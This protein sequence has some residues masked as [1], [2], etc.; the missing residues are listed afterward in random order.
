MGGYKIRSVERPRSLAITELLLALQGLSLLVGGFYELAANNW[1]L[2]TRLSQVGRFL[3]FALVGELSIA[4]V[5][6]G[7]GVLLLLTTL[8]LWRLSS[9]AWT[10]AVALQGINLLMA[11]IE[12]LRHRPH[13]PAM[14]MGVAIALY[15]NQYEVLLAF[16]MRQAE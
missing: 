11:L 9:L 15:L 16:K 1:A 6:F 2:E 13:Y 4:I 5:A 12:H 7:I 8:T 10:L 3:P 14:L